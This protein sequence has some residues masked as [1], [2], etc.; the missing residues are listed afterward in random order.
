MAS[1]SIRVDEANK[2]LQNGHKFLKTSLLKWQP[3]HDNAA[4]QF[5]QAAMA[6]KG[7][8]LHQRAIEA[9]DL[10]IKSYLATGTSD[11][12][13]AKCLEQCALSYKELGNFKKVS[14]YYLK[15]IDIYKN[16]GQL[17][18][19]ISVME[20]A[21][22]VLKSELP[23]MAAELYIQ[24]SEACAI[25]DRYRQAAEFC[26][27]AALLYVKAKE[28]QRAANIAREEINC[29]LQA[30]SSLQSQ[31]VVCLI[32]IHLAN[33]NIVGANDVIKSCQMDD[34]AYSKAVNLV[35]AFDKMDA[36]AIYQILGHSYFKYLD[37]EYAKLAR[38]LQT[39]HGAQKVET[40][41]LCDEEKA[42]NDEQAL[43]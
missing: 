12:Q 4:N 5:I 33:K 29:H 35:A 37:T 27:N 31:A 10:A 2:F 14:E 16:S 43:L 3:D 22:K 32:L 23:M 13:A 38:E 26:S 15:A 19:A 6:F 36:E 42:I 41:V 17:D 28:Y 21:A 20:R 40:G 7:A 1:I 8:G 11:F 9:N 18:T 39:T 25:E 30:G 34:D 24:A